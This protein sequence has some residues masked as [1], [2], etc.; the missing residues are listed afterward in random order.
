MTDC[1][2]LVQGSVWRL[3]VARRVLATV[4]VT[5][6]EIAAVRATAKVLVLLLLLLLV[7]AALQ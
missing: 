6:G 1:G 5:L 4:A 3:V 2:G 7:Q